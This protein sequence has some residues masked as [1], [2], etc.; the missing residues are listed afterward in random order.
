MPSAVRV[1]RLLVDLDV[2]PDV[3]DLGF[4]QWDATDHVFRT[5]AVPPTTPAGSNRSLQINN[6]GSFG[7]VSG[8]TVDA[9][10][11]LSVP[12][13]SAMSGRFSVRSLFGTAKTVSDSF[14]PYGSLS[15]FGESGLALDTTQS[16]SFSTAPGITSPDTSITRISA[17]VVG[18]PG[19]Q[20]SG[21]LNIAATDVLQN[22][23][24]K[25]LVTT[26]NNGLRI[27]SFNHT[28]VAGFFGNT[29]SWTLAANAPL[30]WQSDNTLDSGNQNVGIKPLGAASLKIT[31]GST[32]LGSLTAGEF[33][34]DTYKAVS[35]PLTSIQMNLPD[36]HG[37]TMTGYRG[38]DFING[39]AGSNTRF[40]G[41]SVEIHDGGL[42]FP[43][44]NTYD[45][46]ASGAK[47]RSGYFGH[48]IYARDEVHAG[49]A[50]T[51]DNFWQMTSVADGKLLLWN[52]SS[53]GFD[54]IQMGGYTNAFPSI[55]RN[56]AGIDFK[57]ADGS[58]LTSI[59]AS[60]ITSATGNL[61]LGTGGGSSGFYLPQG[62]VIGTMGGFFTTSNLFVSKVAFGPVNGNWSTLPSIVANGSGIDFKLADGSALTNIAS[63]INLALEHRV[64]GRVFAKEV[65]GEIWLNSG[66]NA[67]SSN[68]LANDN[69]ALGVTVAETT[70]GGYASFTVAGGKSVFGGNVG[71]GTTSPFS[72]LANTATNITDTAGTGVALGGIAWEI[73]DLGY[74][75]AFNQTNG[76]ADYANGL[77]V[78]INS[79]SNT[80]PLLN[81]RS[82]GGGGVDRFVV[83]GAG[84]VGIGTT[85]PGAKLEVAGMVQASALTVG[86]QSILNSGN[87]SINTSYHGFSIASEAGVTLEVSHNGVV[88]FYGNEAFFAMGDRYDGGRNSATQGGFYKNHGVFN[89]W[90]NALGKNTVS[91]ADNGDMAIGVSDYNA[92]SGTSVFSNI[93]AGFYVNKML[94]AFAGDIEC[95]NSAFGMIQKDRGDGLRKRLVITNNVITVEDAD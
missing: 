34:A 23:A 94:S 86:T 28:P 54:A 61:T 58:A 66:A 45:I 35:T 18:M 10:G 75:G 88:G 73:S 42:L 1:P 4:L 3:V 67:G 80:N 29:P 49:G 6:A 57:L 33:H 65:S 52:S 21:A 93:P 24:G 70:Y 22:G 63:N 46:G 43:Q 5:V 15:F 71:I 47:P 56:G 38:L 53:N 91:I 7:A 69:Q 12:T 72:K 30:L 76:T 90:N 64:N 55:A 92:P 9:F 40:Y 31:D 2:D 25:L 39:N 32:G 36:G 44:D 14:N 16:V 87:L 62:G 11:E 60:E 8:V 41:K 82:G 17:G 19:L 68:G 20:L 84:N 89:F 74:V 27:D 51:L 78:H 13:L 79:T 83:T 37:I 48:N 85:T 59:A 50:V 95:T 77:L 81:L 26:V